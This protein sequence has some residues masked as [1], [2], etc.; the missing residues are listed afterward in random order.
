MKNRFWFHFFACFM[1][2]P[3][4]SS[5]IH[6]FTVEDIQGNPVD[7]AQYKGKVLLIVNTASRCGFTPQ[8][9]ELVQ[10]Q[11]DLG[12]QAFTVMG[13]PAN[14]FG[15]QEPG[16]NEQIAQFCEERFQVNFPM[17]SRISVRGNDI[18]P[19]FAFLT[20]AENPDFTGQIRW[21]FEKIL[22]GPDGTVLRRFR[23][24]TRPDSPQI[25]N[26]IQELLQSP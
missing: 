24:N 9:A 22:V 17:F 5:G 12:G 6:G 11:Q 8:Y 20:E 2:L 18:H 21:N 14:N 13:F 19:L 10:L 7:L 4:F 16:S 25:R 3:A 1:A 23:S 15:N 26:A